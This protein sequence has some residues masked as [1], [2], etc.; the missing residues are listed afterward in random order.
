MVRHW[1]DI[2]LLSMSHFPEWSLT[3][4]SGPKFMHVLFKMHA[5]YPVHL[6]PWFN[7][8]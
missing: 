6:I 2:I 4:I 5:T 7:N 3:I 1:I 8:F